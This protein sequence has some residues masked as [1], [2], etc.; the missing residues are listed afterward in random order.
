VQTLERTKENAWARAWRLAAAGLRA[1]EI[2]MVL[3]ICQN[4][5][6]ER[7]RHAGVGTFFLRR[8]AYRLSDVRAGCISARPTFL[9]AADAIR[10]RLGAP[11]AN[12]GYHQ[13]G[14]HPL[15]P[16]TNLNA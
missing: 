5:L 4:P 16:P 1:G 15:G 10:D 13:I 14:F 11:T 9:L 12:V 7:T 3:I 2:R 6:L 8:L